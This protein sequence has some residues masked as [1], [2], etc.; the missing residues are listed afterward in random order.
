MVQVSVRG[1]IGACIPAISI[2]LI[3]IAMFSNGWYSMEGDGEMDMYGYTFNYKL[4]GNYGLREVDADI[5]VTGMGDEY[6][7]SGHEDLED[8]EKTVGTVTLVFLII[9]LV[10]IFAFVTVGI[11]AGL[12][13]IPGWIPMLIGFV[14]IV[15]LI[16]PVIYYPI[17]QPDAVEEGS[18]EAEDMFSEEDLQELFD[19]GTFGWSY[20]LTIGALVVLLPGPFMFIGIKKVKKRPSRDDRPP[21]TGYPYDPYGP[22]PRRDDYYEDRRRDNY[23]DDRDRRDYPPPKV[24]Y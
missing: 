23:Y 4:E 12:H 17:A 13:L 15:C 8:E 1:I 5:E 18:E 20:Y 9:S 10:L 19:S 21:A 24:M 2:I 16:F 3:F 11:V 7:E 14:A 22:P 6:S